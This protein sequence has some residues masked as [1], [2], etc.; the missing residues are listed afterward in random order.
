MRWMRAWMLCVIL[1]LAIGCA[2]M[3]QGLLNGG[4]EGGIYD[5]T[6]G[7]T[8]N[9]CVPDS[10]AV[11]DVL[12]TGWGAFNV[13][14]SVWDG[15][16]WYDPA[17]GVAMCLATRSNQTEWAWLRNDAVFGPG[18][19]YADLAYFPLRLGMGV[20]V[21]VRMWTSGAV[22][23]GALW[24]AYYSTGDWRRYSDE[25]GFKIRLTV[26]DGETGQLYIGVQGENTTVLMD[27]ITVTPVPEP[28]G[29]VVLGMGLIGLIGRMRRR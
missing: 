14:N 10:W 26:P 1:A 5:A 29:M 9:C 18:T 22:A 16:R 23:S 4:F 11:V 17:E 7:S 20:Q 6:P 3:G 12:S 8:G 2:C 19:Y 21:G 15:T 28:A 13:Y 25:T 24:Y 27:D